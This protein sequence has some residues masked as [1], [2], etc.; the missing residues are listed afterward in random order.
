MTVINLHST[1][2]YEYS[3]SSVHS[4]EYSE[5]NSRSQN[6]SVTVQ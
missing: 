6:V 4:N 5:L 1:V 2:E 3:M